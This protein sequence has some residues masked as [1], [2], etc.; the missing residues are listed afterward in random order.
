MDRNKSVSFRDNLESFIDKRVFEGRFKNA[1]KVISV[2]LRLIEEE[3]SKIIALKKA[4][5]A[6]IESGIAENF[7]PKK[8]LE[9]VKATK[10]R[11]NTHSPTMPLMIY[12]KFGITQMKFG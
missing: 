10:K 6:G 9:S 7:D 11:V 8:H 12:P 5:N 1:S 4:I 3:E 2:G